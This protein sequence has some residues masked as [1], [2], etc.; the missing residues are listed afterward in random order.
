MVKVR[1]HL[2]ISQELADILDKVAKFENVTRS[3]I[4]RSAISLIEACREQRAM[5][6]HL[7]FAQDASRLDTEI[8]GLFRLAGGEGCTADSQTAADI[9]MPGEPQP[10]ALEAVMSRWSP[11]LSSQ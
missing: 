8:F 10:I 6:R 7:G 3:E 11:H 1:L 5:G 9:I 2:E 4:V